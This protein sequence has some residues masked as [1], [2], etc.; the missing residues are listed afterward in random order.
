MRSRLYARRVTEDVRSTDESG[1]AGTP[2]FFINGRRH[3]EAYDV[4]ALTAA[5]RLACRRYEFDAAAQR[6]RQSGRGLR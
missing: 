5:I 2:T 1:V 3:Q 6:V 4:E